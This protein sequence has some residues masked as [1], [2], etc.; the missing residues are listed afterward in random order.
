MTLRISTV[1]NKKTIYNS[2]PPQSTFLISWICLAVIFRSMHI[3][4]AAYWFFKFFL[5]D[6]QYPSYSYYSIPQPLFF[7][8]DLN[9]ILYKTF[10]FQRCNS[11]LI[12]CCKHILSKNLNDL[13]SWKQEVNIH[14]NSTMGFTLD[15]LLTEY[16]VVYSEEYCYQSFQKCN[17][18]LL[19]SIVSL[20]YGNCVW[21][22]K[23]KT[24]HKAIFQS[25]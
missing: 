18:I 2:T 13:I 8:Y 25:V 5:N 14:L 16:W 6:L 1:R 9:V 4:P 11:M 20:W 3:L 24:E 12:L 10:Q 17:I 19:D 21:R 7:V 22:L 15:N 23:G